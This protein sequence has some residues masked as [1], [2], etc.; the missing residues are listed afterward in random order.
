MQRLV[1]SF[2]LGVQQPLKLL[3]LL[4]LDLQN[5]LQESEVHRPLE[6]E[7]AAERRQACMCM[8]NHALPSGAD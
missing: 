6:A 3:F 8:Q 7:L 2:L 1:L 4:R 5:A